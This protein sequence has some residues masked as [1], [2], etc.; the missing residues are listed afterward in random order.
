MTP[1]LHCALTIASV[2]HHSC[3]LDS[4]C[5][6]AGFTQHLHLLTVAKGHAV[7]HLM[8]QQ[9]QERMVLRSSPIHN[10][11]AQEAAHRC[12]PMPFLSPSGYSITSHIAPWRL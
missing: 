9:Q 5:K 4:E 1:L 8:Q 11:I 12:S 3:V 2:L 6:N 10:P 7:L